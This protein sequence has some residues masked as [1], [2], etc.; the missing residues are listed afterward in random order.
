[1]NTLEVLTVNELNSLIRRQPV[2]LASNLCI[3][4]F[5]VY[6]ELKANESPSVRKAIEQRSSASQA[7]LLMLREEMK[8]YLRMIVNLNEMNSE[9]LVPHFSNLK[10]GENQL[11]EMYDISGFDR[12]MRYKDNSLN[13]KSLIKSIITITLLSP[14]PAASIVHYDFKDLVMRVLGTQS[15]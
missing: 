8:L 10:Y 13:L 4:D 6:L 2:I 14:N 9:I 7:Y 5:M 15:R 11:L 12:N 3:I 1:M